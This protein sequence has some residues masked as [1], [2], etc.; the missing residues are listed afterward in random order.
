VCAAF[1]ADFDGD[2]MAVHVPLS[3]QA[4]EES[5]KLML[6]THNLLKP[7]DGQPIVGP[8]KDMCLGTYY[9]T[10][11][12]PAQADEE[13]QPFVD[14]D[15]VE[16]AYTLGQIDLH[17]PVVVAY[18]YGH[19]DRRRNPVTTTVGRCLFNRV[20]P[21][22][23]RFINEPMDKRALQD[24]IG[25]CYRRMGVEVTTQVADRIKDIGFEY[26]TRSG[27]TIAISD[28]TIPSEKASIMEKT[29]QSVAEI[30]RQYRRGLLTEEEQYTRVVELWSQTQEQVSKVVSAGLNPTGPVAVMAKSG[31]SK[32]GFNPIAQLAGMRGLMSDPSGRIIEQPIRSSFREGL[33]ALEYFI[34]THGSRKGLA[35]TAMRTA[36]AG[37]LTR[38][39][40]DVVQDIVING[41]DC[42]TTAGVWV[43]STD[44][45]GGQS[46]YERLVGRMAAAPVAHPKTG[47]VLIDRNEEIDEGAA[48]QIEDEGIEAILVRSPTT[49]Q[50]RQGICAMCYGR[51]LG[52]GKMVDIGTAVGIV[53][54]QSIG[55]P[56]TQLTLRTFHTG[57]VA[58]AGDITAG[59]PRVEEV[60]EARKKPKGEA[61][62]SE[63]GGVVH[64]V[65]SDDE[66]RVLVVDSGIE[67]YEHEIKRGWK[68][69]VEDG[70]EVKAGA[71]LATWRDSKEIVAE[72]SGRISI[73]DRKVTLIHERRVEREYKVPATGRLLVEEGQQIKPG[74]QLVEGV[75]NQHNILRIQGREATQRYLLSE[76]QSVYR[77]QG[78]NI[79]DKHL[80][81][82]FRK[83]LGKVQISKSG[84]TDLLPGELVERLALEDI[85]RETVEAGGQP[86]RAWPVLLGI[87]KAALNTESF[88]SAA[89]FQHT[90]KILSAAAVEGKE[91]PLLGLK[92]N[93][94]LGRLIPA[95]TGYRTNGSD[96]EEPI[97]SYENIR[98]KVSAADEE[99]SD[100]AD[101]DREMETDS[102]E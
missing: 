25:V 17:A 20:L 3:Q 29:E 52:R 97:D 78:V 33:S 38:R 92:E 27:V 65:K 8:T 53:A 37:Y 93:V 98:L 102:E 32:G 43:C 45:V 95:G 19:P 51:D 47:E 55:E 13:P 50:L 23:L 61:P 79:N 12:D 83:M 89:S 21:T 28:L 100:A 59:L 18:A 5:R 26:A 87:T 72:K 7:A 4:V 88:L 56:G 36:D 6:A 63:I 35:D 39:L 15:E 46:M 42:G 70:D 14:L 24:L 80:E 9:L 69:L 58:H 99:N 10:M 85:N 81:V 31:A 77:S 74:V 101:D 48:T 49:C 54:A 2:Q 84:D 34:S 22:E 30:N 62:M 67:K 94:I 86:A 44:D 73:E 11:E 82:V 40:V 90:I 66:R 71:P 91:D 76:V 68:I 16:V 41:R 75:L 96:F 1:N 57:G 60:F 64:I